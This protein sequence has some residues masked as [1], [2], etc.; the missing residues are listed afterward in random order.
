MQATR[1]ATRS[2]L[3]QRSGTSHCCSV[4]PRHNLV[5]AVGCMLVVF[6]LAGS[7][8]LAKRISVGFRSKQWPA[9]TGLL[10]SIRDVPGVD[11]PET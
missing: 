2:G 3:D 9:T 8:F 7:L 6:S 10:E 5:V 11:D 1:K 4:L